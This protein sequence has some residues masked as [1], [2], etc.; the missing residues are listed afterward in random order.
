MITGLILD[1]YNVS[2]LNFPIPHSWQVSSLIQFILNNPGLPL[3]DHFYL[4]LSVCLIGHLFQPILCVKEA[5]IVLFKGL[6]YINA[7]RKLAAEPLIRQQQ[8][9][10]QIFQD[11]PLY[12]VSAMLI[13]AYR[14]SG[15]VLPNGRQLVWISALCVRGNICPQHAS[16]RQYDPNWLCHALTQVPLITFPP[17]QTVSNPRLGLWAQHTRGQ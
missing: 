4:Y 6:L 9:S 11:Y 13:C 2:L 5:N 15:N 7:A 14:T 12:F 17:S 1:C 16:L 10:L 3:V 8:L